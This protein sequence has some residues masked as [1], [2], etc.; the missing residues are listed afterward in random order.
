MLNAFTIDLED[1]GQA[2]LDPGLP[3]TQR[4]VENTERVL[5]WL[6]R[7][8][9]RATFFVLGKVCERFPDLLP[10]VAGEGHEI[11]SHGYG[12]EPVFQLSGEDFRRD[13]RRSVQVITSQIGVQPIGYRAPAFSITR[14]SLW[15]GQILSEMGFRYS[16]SIFPIRHRRYGIPEAPPHPYE[17]PNCD[18]IEFPI[19]TY[20]ALGRRWPC[21]GGGYTRLLP[22][23]AMA[24]AIRRVNTAGRPAVGYLHPYEFAPG[25]TRWVAAQGIRARWW[26]RF[27]QELWR[28]R[29]EPRLTR[30]VGEFEFGPM[31][32]ALRQ[33]GCPAP[34]AGCRQFHPSIQSANAYNG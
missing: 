5:D 23:A 12:H 9:I 1:W 8:G 32:E 31:C 27:T 26:G 30:L 10:R 29:V 15:A 11:G 33:A 19:T 7:H 25:E 13:V 18:L 16:S 2:V 3:I 34:G 4:V 20:T 17:W 22:G 21:A 24:R 28:S 14:Y 6:R